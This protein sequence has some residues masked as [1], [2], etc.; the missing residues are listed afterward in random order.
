ME[1]SHV[2]V[3]AARLADSLHEQLF[4]VTEAFLAQKLEVAAETKQ[5]LPGTVS[6]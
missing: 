3:G 1:V 6:M 5:P 4:D 2:D